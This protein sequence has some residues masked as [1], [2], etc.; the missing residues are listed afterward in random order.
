MD[1]IPVN[2]CGE[3]LGPLTLRHVG[4]AHLGHSGH[5]GTQFPCPDAPVRVWCMPGTAYMV[6]EIGLPRRSST[7]AGQILCAVPVCSPRVSGAMGSAETRCLVGQDLI[8]SPFLPHNSVLLVWNM[9]P[10]RARGALCVLLG[11]RRGSV[12]P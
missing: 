4:L 11:G 2:H 9:L 1:P 3:Q 12:L 7:R 5:M 10:P 6:H 8:Q